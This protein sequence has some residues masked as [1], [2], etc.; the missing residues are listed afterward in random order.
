MGGEPRYSS[1]MAPSS[2]QN[3]I[4]R[5]KQL[6]SHSLTGTLWAVSGAA[7]VEG[8]GIAALALL[9]ER[10]VPWPDSG[11]LCGVLV[12]LALGSYWTTKRHRAD[13]LQHSALVTSVVLI[14]GAVILF[15]RGYGGGAIALWVLLAFSALFSGYRWACRASR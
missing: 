2:L 8:L 5:A 14:S 3:S 4:E 1:A 13:H 6:Y 10:L 12:V 11:R 7:F 9:L 15:G